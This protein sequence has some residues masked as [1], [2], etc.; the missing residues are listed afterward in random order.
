MKDQVEST[1]QSAWKY[2]KLGGGCCLV[3]FALFL[4][5]PDSEYIQQMQQLEYEGRSTDAKL[6]NKIE[7]RSSSPTRLPPGVGGA[8]GAAAR[9]FA[10]GKRLSDSPDRRSNDPNQDYGR[11]FYVDYVY[12]T[13]AGKQIESQAI[14]SAEAFDRLAVGETLSVTYLPQN[15]EINRLIDHA[16]PFKRIPQSILVT[17]S[18]IIGSVGALLIWLNWP[19]KATVTSGDAHGGGRNGG[20]GNDRVPR[21]VGFGRVSSPARR[22][23]QAPRK[24]FD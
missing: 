23:F 1:F 6:I 8:A 14:V 10:A 16:E 24:S 21:S 13:T 5:R 9:S 18:I 3:L 7:G 19:S 20:Q 17:V 11:L 4:L 22:G 15:P 2:I 12:K